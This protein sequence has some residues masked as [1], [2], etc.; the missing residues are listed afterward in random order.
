MRLIVPRIMRSRVRLAGHQSFIR[1]TITPALF[2][3]I[4]GVIS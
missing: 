4:D 1:V 2:P 3:G